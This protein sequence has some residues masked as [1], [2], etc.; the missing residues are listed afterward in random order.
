MIWGSTCTSHD[1]KLSFGTKVSLFPFSINALFGKNTFI[2]TPIVGTWLKQQYKNC[3]SAR[4]NL[5]S[6]I[7]LLKHGVT[8]VE[9]ASSM[10]YI[11]SWCLVSCLLVMLHMCLR[12]KSYRL[13]RMYFFM[14]AF[15]KLGFWQKFLKKY[16]FVTKD[17]N[18]NYFHLFK[19]LIYL[20]WLVHDKMLT[21]IIMRT[22]NKI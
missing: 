8:S 6:G 16:R 7:L 19:V 13:P 18:K 17:I 2:L 15:I 21:K 12:L 14:V 3:V 11:K 1:R 9:I 5:L 20:L 22:Q 10:Y 4:V